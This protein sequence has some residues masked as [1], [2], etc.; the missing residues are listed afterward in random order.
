M[1]KVMMV[2]AAA[3][4]TV[5]AGA[6]GPAGGLAVEAPGLFGVWQNPSG[7]VRIRTAKCGA[8]VCGTIV[9]AN[10]RAKADA[11]R[12]GTPKLVGLNLFQQFVGTAPG[13]WEGKV[14]V[15]DL[16]RTVSGRITLVDARRMSVEG[17]VFGY[18]G[19]TTQ[20]WTRVA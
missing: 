1:P 7:S 10:A 19:C 17:C 2:L 15:P 13:V 20:M 8:S 5:P 9:Y 6:G 12:G 18:V 3:L 4:L 11:A 14:L 16:A